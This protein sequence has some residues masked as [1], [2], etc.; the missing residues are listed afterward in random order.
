[1]SK[2][3]TPKL[4]RSP[5]QTL[6]LP[7]PFCAINPPPPTVAETQRSSI[8]ALLQQMLM[9][10]VRAEVQTRASKNQKETANEQ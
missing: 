5:K 9:G 6:Q 2:T 10:A 3:S 4:R 1:M 8:V 7:L